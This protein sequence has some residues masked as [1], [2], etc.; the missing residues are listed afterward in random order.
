MRSVPFSPLNRP[1]A[2]HSPNVSLTTADAARLLH[3]K[4]QTLRKHHCLTGHFY[5]VRPAKLPTGRL[6]WPAEGV[7]NI[8]AGASHHER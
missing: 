8:F 5:G 7:A 2:F 3:C 4:P 6:A 1:S